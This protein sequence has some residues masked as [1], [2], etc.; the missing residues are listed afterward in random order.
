M[1]RFFFA[2]ILCSCMWSKHSTHKLY[3]IFST[4]TLENIVILTINRG[5]IHSLESLTYEKNFEN[6]DYMGTFFNAACMNG[7]LEI[8]K[9]LY[10]YYDRNI[11]HYGYVYDFMNALTYDHAHILEWL[12]KLPGFDDDVRDHLVEKSYHSEHTKLR[13]Y[14]ETKTI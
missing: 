8:A 13:T 12:Q 14:L 11:H 7:N 10:E 2:I 3:D 5:D 4:E 6:A 9:L 1:L